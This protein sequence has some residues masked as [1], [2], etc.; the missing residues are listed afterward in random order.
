MIEMQKFISWKFKLDDQKVRLIAVSKTHPKDKIQLM[1]DWGQQ[2]FG[3]NKVQEMV[4]KYNQLP[5][6]IK[7]HMIGHLQRNKVKEI[8]PFVHLIH[9]V[10][11]L[12]LIRKI[13][14]ES[15][16]I[17]RI[18]SV[19][20]QL[21]IAEEDTKYGLSQNN[22]MQIAQDYVNKKFP[23]IAIHGLMGMASFVED[24]HQ[25][26]REFKFLNHIFNTLSQGIL[27]D[28]QDF[29]IRSIGMSGDYKIAIDCGSNMIRVGSKIFGA[30]NYG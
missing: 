13:N 22:L 5:S 18:T 8:V 30:R 7:W 15:Q 14:L 26:E 28:A 3:E 6:D 16:K 25:I 29:K 2:D 17:N 24:E 12:R 10:D 1:Y 23:N 20:L 19:L 27:K 21:K 4:E 11:S 9:S